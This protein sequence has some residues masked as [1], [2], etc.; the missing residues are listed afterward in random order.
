M[1]KSTVEITTWLKLRQKKP[2]LWIWDPKINKTNKSNG[3][4]QQEK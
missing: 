3:R 4:N 2:S 1:F